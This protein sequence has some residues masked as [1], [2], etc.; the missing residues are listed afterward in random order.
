MLAFFRE[1]AQRYGLFATSSDAALAM[2]LGCDGVLLNTA[3]SDAEQ[4]ILMTHSMRMAIDAGRAA[5]RAGR[6][7]VRGYAKSSS[8]QQGLIDKNISAITMM[9]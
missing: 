6:M 1:L 3:L 7:P 9:V 8:P 4:P 2:E 5:Y